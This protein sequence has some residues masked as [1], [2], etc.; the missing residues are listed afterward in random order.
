MKYSKSFRGNGSR[1]S[2]G[3]LILL[4][5]LIIFTTASAQDAAKPATATQSTLPIEGATNLQGIV[6]VDSPLPPAVQLAG[7]T[8]VRGVE[9]KGPA[10][11]RQPQFE[12]MLKKH[13]GAPLTDQSLTKLQSEILDYCR[14][15]NRQVVD[16]L[17]PEQDVVDGTVQI[18]VVVGRVDQITVTNEN[19]KWFSDSLILGKISL[20]TNDVVLESRLNDNLNWL[21]ANNYQSLEYDPFGGSFRSV[22][23]NLARGGEPNNPN[24]IGKTDIRFQVQDRFPLRVFAGY[25][26]EGMQVLGEDQLFAG[27]NYANVFGLDQRLN[28]EY[29]TDSDSDKLSEH[30]ASYVIPLP[31]RQEL[32][33]MGAYANVNPELSVIS[34][35]LSSLTENG[36]YYQISGHYSISLPSYKQFDHEIAVGYDFKNTDTPLLFSGS[37]T[38][39]QPNQI[40]ID[41]FTLSYSGR[42]RDGWGVSAFSLQG[43][44]SPGGLTGY[45]NDADFNAMR[46]GTKAEYTYGRAEFRRETYLS[47]AIGQTVAPSRFTWDLTASGQLSDARLAPPEEFALGGYDTVRGYNERVV[48]ADGGWLLRNEIRTPELILGNLT[49][50]QNKVDWIQGLIFCDYG[51]A[52]T[53]DPNPAL[54]E[55]YEETLLS[56]GAGLRYQI[57]DNL[58]FRLDY[59]YQLERGYATTALNAASL[60]PQPNSRVHL[61]VE[62]SY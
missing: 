25:Q 29:L 24:D 47:P 42:I 52:I 22:A 38:T 40:D 32:S 60:G 5:A 17:T 23:A 57:A 33:I 43:V 7:V 49:G 10:F 51:R 44:E 13:L 50:R 53:K 21:N 16:V 3:L 56:V 46:T 20:K 26:D 37:A 58:C 45:N 2:T 4:S 11:L 14:A 61:A 39:L 30:V 35:G 12:N 36:T 28:Y 9:I 59:G 1:I 34:P 15:H 27:F 8:G 54:L 62:I 6:V 41:Q 31:R 48:N 18:A 19:R 55:S